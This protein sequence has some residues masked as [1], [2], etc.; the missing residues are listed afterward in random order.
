MFL[1]AGISVPAASAFFC[2]GLAVWNFFRPDNVFDLVS[3]ASITAWNRFGII[4]KNE[5][6]CFVI[7]YFDL[8]EGQW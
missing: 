1:E 8:V 2:Q 3:C 7:S 5:Q 4:A 6:S